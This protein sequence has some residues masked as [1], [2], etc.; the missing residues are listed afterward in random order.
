MISDTKLIILSIVII[1]GMK[2]GVSIESHN[3]K[4]ALGTTPGPPGSGH[5]NILIFLYLNTK[6]EA[7]QTKGEL[8]LPRSPPGAPPQI[9][10]VCVRE[11]R[12]R[13]SEHQQFRV[14]A[15]RTFVFQ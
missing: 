5:Y 13:K 9:K 14:S 10:H 8:L 15:I 11:L 1:F 4:D 12:E 7:V 6:R 3:T 2:Q